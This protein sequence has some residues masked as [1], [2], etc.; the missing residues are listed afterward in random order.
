ME[1][2]ALGEMRLILSGVLIRRVS[3]LWKS[4]GTYDLSGGGAYRG[5][6]YG[7]PSWII[8]PEER[9]IIFLDEPNRLTEKGGAVE[10][11]YRQSRMHREEKGSRNLPEN[12]LCSFEQ[13]QKN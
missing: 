3:V 2:R 5:Q 7:F 6:G 12:W 4:G 9:T 11:E 10:E 13:L 1:N 8:F